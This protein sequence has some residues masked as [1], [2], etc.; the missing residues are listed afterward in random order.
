MTALDRIHRHRERIAAAGWRRIQVELSPDAVRALARLQ[1]AGG[2]KRDI[3]AAA[4][5]DA[6]HRSGMARKSAGK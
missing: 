1:Q 3:I 4:L 5:L 2:T 6:D